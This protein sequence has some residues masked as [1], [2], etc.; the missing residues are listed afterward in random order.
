[1]TTATGGLR[2][3]LAELV[4]ARGLSLL[5]AAAGVHALANAR[6]TR[7]LRSVSSEIGRASCRERVSYHV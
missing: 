7:A 2:G 3:E 6:M 5:D 4:A 1:M